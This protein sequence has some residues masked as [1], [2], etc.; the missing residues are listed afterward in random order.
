MWLGRVG[1]WLGVRRWARLVTK[2]GS[3]RDGQPLYEGLEVPDGGVLIQD[4][5]VRRSQGA[6]PAG[7]RGG[8][9]PAPGTVPASCRRDRQPAAAGGQAQPAT[10]R[11]RE[12]AIVSPTS[13]G[14]CR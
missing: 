6:D 11:D 7:H 13:I 8:A 5:R 14:A 4:R 1:P 9:T 2:K 3:A 10:W 12:V